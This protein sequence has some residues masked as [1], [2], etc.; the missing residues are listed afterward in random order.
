MAAREAAVEMAARDRHA[1]EREIGEIRVELGLGMAGEE[2]RRARSSA[3]RS[4][5]PITVRRGWA[6]GSPLPPGQQDRGPGSAFEVAG[7]AGEARHQEERRAVVI[8]RHRHEGGEG[9][10][11]SGRGSRAPAR[12]RLAGAPCAGSASKSG[13][14]AGWLFMAPSGF[15]SPGCPRSRLKTRAGDLLRS[16]GD[17]ARLGAIPQRPLAHRIRNASGQRPN[18]GRSLPC[19]RSPSSTTIATS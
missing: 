18:R 8:G 10:P 19:Q 14:R 6:S 13:G 3:V 1:Q 7:M 17:M 15:I 5:R 12:M 2:A 4:P 11:A 9:E 16:F